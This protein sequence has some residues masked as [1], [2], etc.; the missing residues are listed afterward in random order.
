M[1][2]VASNKVGGP[3]CSSSRPKSAANARSH[4][5]PIQRFTTSAHGIF[6]VSRRAHPVRSRSLAYRRSPMLRPRPKLVA[7]SDHRPPPAASRKYTGRA[8][9]RN[10]ETWPLLSRD[11]ASRLQS[12]H[13]IEPCCAVAMAMSKLVGAAV[14]RSGWDDLPRDLLESVLGRLPVP[15]RLRFPGVCTAWQSADAASATARFRA[16]QPPW[17]MLPFNPTARRQSPGDGGGGID[18]GRFLE[19]RFLSLSD[20]R[21]YAIRQPAPA[22]SERLCVGSSNGWLVTAD[23]A[24]ELHLLN[25]LTGAQVQLPSV[26]TLPFVDASRDADGRVVSYDLRCCFGEGNNG[27]EVLVPPESFAPD[28]LRYELYE[29]AILVAPPRRQTPLGSW[30]GYAVLLIC[31]PLYRLA[32]ARAGDTKW[33]LLDTPSRCWVDAVRASSVLGGAAAAADHQAVYTLDSVGRVEAWDMDVTAGT[34][35][36]PPKE[37]APPCYCSGRACSMSIPCSKYLVEL[38]PGHLLQVHRLRDKAYARYKWEPRQE[39]VE[40]TTVKAELFEWKVGAAAAHGQWA[41]VDSKGGAGILA[42]RAL[43]LGKSA[44]LCVPVDCCPEVRGNCVYFTDDGPWSHERCHEVVPDVGV[45]NLAD[46]SYNVPRGAVRDMLW[47]W[48]PPVWVFPSCTN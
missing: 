16:V 11:L 24:S 5:R 46:R 33:T 10:S 14:R 36:A 44:S 17:L 13:A 12:Q 35:P 40:Y 22:V 28:R 32:I 23:A 25:P 20:G 21:A 45:L 31:Q 43:F 27:D 7:V 48:P 34:M 42:G 41:R 4:R 30:G 38:S 39:L 47:K 8:A 6:T 15:D 3:N 18:D 1:N 19:A 37:I 9:R 26:T 2:Q 29:K